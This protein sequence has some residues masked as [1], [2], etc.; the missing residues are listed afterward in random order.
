MMFDDEIWIPGEEDNHIEFL[1]AIGE[2]NDCLT[3]DDFEQEH[4][5]GNQ[6]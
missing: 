4:E 5:N 3:A 1:G 6:M 2:S